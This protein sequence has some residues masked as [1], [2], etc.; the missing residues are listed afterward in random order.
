MALKSKQD[1]KDVFSGLS[2]IL[3]KK[4]G[5][6]DFSSLEPDFDL[7]VTV[8]SL[9]LTVGEP[10]MNSVKV[11]GLQL[12]WAVTSTPGEVTFA[13][14]VPS[15]DEDLVEYFTGKKTS[16][17]S[18]SVKVAEGENGTVAMKGFSTTLTSKKI[19]AGIVLLNEA[20]D[21]AVA[22]KQLAIYAR[23]LFENASTT[24]F[25]FALSGTLEVATEGATGDDIAF[26]KKV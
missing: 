4:D 8:D 20:Q 25:A 3:L 13:A 22:I 5:F 19:N 23:P 16:I 9:S 24:P 18:A 21:Q 14:T 15:I 2:S 10:T 6:K 17:A 11:H 7:P 1:L 26:L 12:D